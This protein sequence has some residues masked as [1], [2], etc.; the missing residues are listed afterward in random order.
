MSSRSIDQVAVRRP[1]RDCGV[2]ELANELRASSRSAGGIRFARKG[3]HE[4][5][6]RARQAVVDLF[7]WERFPDRL[8]LLTMPG[9]SWEF[10]N[11]LLNSREGDWW[12]RRRSDWTRFH[13]C[14]SDR[15]VYHAAL[16]TL[17][18][19]KHRTCPIKVFPQNSFAEKVVGNGFVW[20]YF[21]ANTDDLLRAKSGV[22]SFDGAWL[23]YTG[24]LTIKRLA[25]IARFFR[26]SIRETLVITSLKARWNV[27]TGQAIA[28]SGGHSE[29]IRKTIP[30][31]VLHDIEYQDG[32]SPMSQIAIQHTD[33]TREASERLLPD[34]WSRGRPA[35]HAAGGAR[36]AG[37]EA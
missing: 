35:G 9:V 33:E 5:K 3:E 20:K 16:L 22:W 2:E 24:P 30:G 29:W 37:G 23:D 19:I 34:L 14:E 36:R 8:S 31:V 26:E 1:L 7:S 17:P 12:G 10:E 15:F 32:Q 27:E 4:Q 21:L 18:G 13:C 11:A 6:D 25:L 28:R